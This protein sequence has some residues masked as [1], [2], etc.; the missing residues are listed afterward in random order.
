MN[1]HIGKPIDPKQL[2]AT[3]LAWIKPRSATVAQTR[4]PRAPDEVLPPALLDVPGLDARIGLD[5]LLGKTASYV[6]LLR[7]FTANQ[8]DTEHAIKAALAAGNMDEARRLAHTLKGLAAT[9][10]AMPLREAAARLE[11]ALEAGETHE[12]V[13]SACAQTALALRTLREPLAAALPHEAG[14][15]G[16]AEVDPAAVR[17]VCAELG[18]ALS[19]GSFDAQALLLQHQ[20]LLSAALGSR[21][22]AVRNGV[23]NFDFDGAAA[24]LTAAMTALAPGHGEA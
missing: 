8:A 3:L 1:D 20:P 11:A 12:T 17:A 6:G 23:G 9:I 10:G 15:A 14:P 18:A 21:F 4:P 22:D 5:R 24:A 7:R 16:A 2:W 13:A 19:A